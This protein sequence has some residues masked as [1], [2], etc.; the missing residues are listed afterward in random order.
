M[1]EIGRLASCRLR[2]SV[3]YLPPNRRSCTFVSIS[4]AESF[5]TLIGLRF[6]L[7]IPKS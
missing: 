6:L 3:L 4:A 1:I 2:A 5:D 7:N